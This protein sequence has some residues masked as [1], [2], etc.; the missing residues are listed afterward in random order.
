MDTDIIIVGS[1]IAGMVLSVLLTQKGVE[2]IVLSREGRVAD[3]ALAETLPPSALPL[4]QKMGVLELFER[5]AIQKTYGYHSVW[6]RPVVADN[7]FFLHRPYQYG[8]KI[9][10]AAIIGE[11]G[12]QQK[13]RLRYYSKEWRLQCSDAGIVATWEHNGQAATATGKIIVDATG[14]KRAVLNKLGIGTTD[15]DGLTAFSCHIPYIKHPKLVHSVVVEAFEEGWGIASRLDE[16]TNVM[17]LF[18]HL[19]NPV[20]PLLKHVGNWRGVLSATTYLKELLPETTDVRVKGSKANSSKAQCIAGK[21]WLAVGDAAI[22]FD[23]LSSHGVT[24]A[25]Y[26]VAQ[27]TTAITQHLQHGAEDALD[28]YGKTLSDI[29]AQYLQTKDHIY[30]TE[31]RWPKS[32]FWK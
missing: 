10:K 11:L 28:D 25:L 17:T 7:N 2:H 30:Q 31:R 26:T 9:D 22:S 24:N 4:L 23:P 5:T 15:Y 14:R 29:F 13:M 19:R 21:N 1:G 8:L 32:N 20:L 12:Q 27:A 18:T 16:A 6:G 3:L